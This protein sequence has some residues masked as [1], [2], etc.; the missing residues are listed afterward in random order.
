MKFLLILSLVLSLGF[1]AFASNTE[2]IASYE[3]NITKSSADLSQQKF[4]SQMLPFPKLL[5]AK[6]KSKSKL[7]FEELNEIRP[8]LISYFRSFGEGKRIVIFTGATSLDPNYKPKSITNLNR[9]IKK[10]TSGVV[11]VMQIMEKDI[12]R[13]TGV[14]V[15]FVTPEEFGIHYQMKYQDIIAVLAKNKELKKILSEQDTLA[16]HI[17]VED[18]LGL[19]AKK[20]LESKRIP[21]TSAYHTD[22]AQYAIGFSQFY[23]P[24]ILHNALMGGPKRQKFIEK[25]LYKVLKGFHENSQGIMVPTKT[26]AEKLISEG[27]PKDKIRYWSHGVDIELFN[28]Q[29]RDEKIYEN[30]FKKAG[31]NLNNRP[32]A[33][34]V[35]RVSEEK[36]IRDFLDAKLETSE[37]NVD[38]TVKKMEA[39][40]V[41]VGSGPELEVLKVEY[42]EVLFLGRKDHDKELPALMAS[43]DGFVFP[44]LT[45]TFGLV[46]PEAMAAGTPVLSY[47]TQGMKDWNIEPKAGLMV[48]YTKDRTNNLKN[49]EEGWK[50]IRA[51]NRNDVRA[52]A[53]TIPWERSI[54]EF[55]YFL[56]VMTPEQRQTLS[57]LN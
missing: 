18:Q 57:E 19:A 12:K 7:T 23:L 28:P 10:Q 29:L 16:V 15:R 20:F 31:M 49:L 17:M 37:T 36:N 45:E 56:K 42:P 51:L 4:D 9:V 41:V 47:Y 50:S 52:Y 2:C 1:G 25:Q 35:G 39:A 11:T 8:E 40:K 3:K 30:E 32:V 6:L 5:S 43:A 13:L 33:L 54:L 21:Y 48:D 44:S 53:E 14:D 55:L 38:G 26:M 22:F 34:F 46:G 27:F 24:S